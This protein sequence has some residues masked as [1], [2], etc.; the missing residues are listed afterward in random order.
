[1]EKTND[2]VNRFNTKLIQAERLSAENKE[3]LDS[4]DNFRRK[5]NADLMKLTGGT[6]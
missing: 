4:V 1:M 3:R 5:V 6:P 2:K